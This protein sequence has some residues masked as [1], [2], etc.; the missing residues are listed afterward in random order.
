MNNASPIV[1]IRQRW[2]LIVVF[3]ALGALIGWL[4]QPQKVEQQATSYS[5]TNTSLVN[6]G[7]NSATVSVSQ[8]PLL[9]VAGEV[10]ARVA[11]DI[12]YSGNSAQLASQVDVNVDF[13]TSALT[14]STEQ[15]TAEQ[16]ELVAN[17]FADELSA[18]LAER[19]DA[20]I[21]ARKTAAQARVDALS[22]ELNAINDQVVADPLNPILLAQR[23][24]L[25]RE[26]GLP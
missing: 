18:Y 17:T 6:D 25:A 2:W 10:P 11:T 24:A 13:E 21:L 15:D 26:Y 4:P 16:A 22:T 20:D 7:G 14:I 12:N 3:A 19:Q 9:A 8:I 5:A 23:D 1:A